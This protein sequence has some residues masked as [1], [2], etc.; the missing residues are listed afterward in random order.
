MNN[1][2]GQGLWGGHSISWVHGR[3]WPG[4]RSDNCDWITQY[5][6]SSFHVISGL[7][8]LCG[9]TVQGNRSRNFPGAGLAQA[10]RISIAVGRVA[11]G[12]APEVNADNRDLGDSGIAHP[13]EL[14]LAQGPVGCTGDLD[15]VSG[16][17]RRGDRLR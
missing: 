15:P 9:Q 8:P 2:Q 4:F 10:A 3:P 5:Q 11:S 16:A 12:A 14:I 7:A 6:G 13:K 1:Y 17:A